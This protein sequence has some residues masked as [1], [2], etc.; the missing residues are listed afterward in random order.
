VVAVGAVDRF[1][2]DRRFVGIRDA[3]GRLGHAGESSAASPGF[4]HTFPGSG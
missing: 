1:G 4:D 2:I 3:A